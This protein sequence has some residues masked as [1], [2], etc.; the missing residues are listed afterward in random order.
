MSVE[1][2]HLGLSCAALVAF[3]LYTLMLYSVKCN[4]LW[5]RMQLF[6]DVVLLLHIFTLVPTS[7]VQPLPKLTQV[8]LIGPLSKWTK[9]CPDWTSISHVLNF[10]ER[11]ST[12]PGEVDFFVLY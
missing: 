12:A 11:L 5:L 8:K 9:S 4:Q 2:Q 6:H 10:P 7:F 3:S 1:K